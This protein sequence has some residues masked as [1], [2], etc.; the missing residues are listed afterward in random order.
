MNGSRCTH[1]LLAGAVAIV[2]AASP[3][4]VAKSA[5]D[6]VTVKPDQ[7]TGN[8]VL[9][10]EEKSAA[11]ETE[12]VAPDAAS[13]QSAPLAVDK[14]EAQPVAPEDKPASA[15]ATDEQAAPGAAEAVVSQPVA[16]DSKPE[17]PDAPGE[18]AAP[19]AAEKATAQS[20]KTKGPDEQKRQ[21]QI[22]ELQQQLAEQ[23]R[24][25]DAQR[26]GA[27]EQQKKLDEQQQQLDQQQS[28]IVSQT[29][30]LQAMQKQLDQI[31]V[32]TKQKRDEDQVALRA[33]LQSLETTIATIP[34]SPEISEE[35]DRS[36]GVPGTNS[37]FRIGGFVKM[38]L[39]DSLDPIGSEDRFITG[40]IP[41]SGSTA[42]DEGGQF[43]VSARQSRVNIEEREQ[44]RF[45]VLRAFVEGDFAGDG[46][47]FR[48]RHAF[49]QFRD[50]LAGKTWSNMVDTVAVPEEVDFEGIN[51]R[52]QVRQPQFRYFPPFGQDS[53]FIISLED[54]NPDVTGGDGKSQWPDVALSI[55]RTWFERW[56]TKTSVLLRQIE[57]QNTAN[58]MG[59]KSE[60]GWGASVSGKIGAGF[61]NDDDN[62]SFQFNIGDGLG[63][64]I[65]DLGSVGGQDAVFDPV[66][67]EL[68]TLKVTSGYLS[69]QHWWNERMRSTATYSWVD[70]DNLSFQL[71]VDYNR[72][73][74][75]SIN[76]IWSPIRDMEIGTEF[77]W[78]QRVNND[79]SSGTAKQIQVATTYR[80]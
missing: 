70:V 6:N 25:L 58:P 57:A 56:R 21:D 23:N 12:P 34:E 36:I 72:T 5:E 27:A 7:V 64:Y 17:S 35:F 63:R 3:L 39:V 32:D 18:Q 43:S 68:E 79:L 53:N 8:D 42:G 78:G 13:G 75:A 14:A 46:D 31:A 10:P 51:G 4:P 76:F 74:R 71:P 44:T 59:I 24:Q 80:F 77:L 52:L 16:S 62:F 30:I 54:P 48:L 45:G 37:A 1:W 60:F 15:D 38:S 28:Q 20:E 50:L 19:V 73:K 55:D 69:F 41:P 49:G 9:T 66:T 67:G 40:S 22:K 29:S 26:S 33:R 11:Q 2:F 47:T 61:W 65:N